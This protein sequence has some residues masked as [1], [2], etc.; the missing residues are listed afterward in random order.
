[1]K[2]DSTTVMFGRKIAED[3]TEDVVLLQEELTRKNK[4]YFI[5]KSIMNLLFKLRAI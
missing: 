3:S 1:M 5:L 4:K 2:E